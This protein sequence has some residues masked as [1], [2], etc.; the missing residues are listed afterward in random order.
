MFLLFFLSFIFTSSLFLSRFFFSPSV[1]LCLL[2]YLAKLGLNKLGGG[3]GGDGGF[4]HV[5]LRCI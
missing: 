5:P 2:L 4:E 3:G 1:S